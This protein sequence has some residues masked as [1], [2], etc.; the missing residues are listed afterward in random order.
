M[1]RRHFAL[2]AAGSLLACASTPSG[3]AP[4]PVATPAPL[5][6]APASVASANPAPSASAPPPRRLASP[7]PDAK[8]PADLGRAECKKGEI[9]ACDALAEYWGAREFLP[10]GRDAE[11]RGDA[12][13]LKEACESKKI[14]SACMGYALMLKYGLATG[15]RDNDAAKPYWA[16]LKEL[17][18]LNGFR[19]AAS[20]EGQA[21]LRRAQQDCDEGRARSCTQVGWAAY[22]GVQRD[23]STADAFTA[24][25]EACRL[26]SALGCRWAGHYAHTY[27]EIGQSASTKKLLERSCE[28]QNPSGCAELGTFTDTHESGAMA[29]QLMAR[30]CDQG[31]RDGCMMAGKKLLDVKKERANAIARLRSACDAEQEEACDLLGPLLERGDGAKKDE[32][33]AIAAYTRGCQGKLEA[34]CA[35]LGRLSGSDK[36]DK[37]PLDLKPPTRIGE[38]GVRALKQSCQATLS[39]PWCKGVKSCADKLTGWARQGEDSSHRTRTGCINLSL[40]RLQKRFESRQLRT[41]VSLCNGIRSFMEHPRR[42]SG[43]VETNRRRSHSRRLHEA[44]SLWFA[45]CPWSAAA[46]A[47]RGGGFAVHDG[48]GGP[49]AACSGRAAR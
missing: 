6:S 19:D 46:R 21:T 12:E 29:L 18:D 17:G 30:A 24:Y 22:N 25:A 5:A 16:R 38:K 44:S 2:I 26:G 13:T 40:L 28:G 7:A 11:A 43:A 35:A 31:S 10:A 23:K 15:K 4:A 14:S 8:P 41:I 49:E 47:E 9:K 42:A 45:Y 27:P 20:S 3:P 36:S 32:A 37:C 34:S 1:S 48:S 33:A 39:A